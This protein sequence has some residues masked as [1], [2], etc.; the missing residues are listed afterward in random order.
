[1]PLEPSVA[2]EYKLAPNEKVVDPDHAGGTPG[3]YNDVLE[4]MAGIHAGDIVTLKP[5][6]ANKDFTLKPL[7]LEFDLTVRGYP[8]TFPTLTLADT[9]LGHAYLFR[10][11][12]GK[13]HLENLHI[14]L[15]AK[16]TNISLSLVNMVGNGTCSLKNCTVSLKPR[17]PANPRAFPISVVTMVAGDDAKAMMNDNR[18]AMS[19]SF[20]KLQNCFV[21]GE[22]DVVTLRGSRPVTLQVGGS[23]LIT[24]GSLVRQLQAPPRKLPIPMPPLP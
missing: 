12:E 4:A 1:M 11:L 18:P 20:I 7:D 16:D 23:L 5:G 14:V 6:A 19:A 9:L 24:G 8:G 21:R 10:L 3:Y 22:G 2:T 13:L 17:D 15:E